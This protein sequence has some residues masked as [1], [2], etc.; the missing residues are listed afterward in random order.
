MRL[1]LLALVALVLP[2]AGCSARVQHGLDERQANEI[3]TVLMERGFRARKVVEEGRPPAWSVE[4]ESV[5]AADAVRVLAELGLPR[6]RPAGVRELLKPGLVPDPVE[7]HA[8]LLEAQSGELARTLEA[9]DG[10][11]SARVHLVRPQPTRT[12][13]PSSPTKAAV[14]LRAQPAASAHLQTVKDELRALVAG[15]V[16][17]LEPAAVTLVVSEVVSTVPPRAPAPERSAW[18]PALLGG[19]VLALG[20]A[21]GGGVLWA[22]RRARRRAA[23]ASLAL[24]PVVQSPLA[25]RETA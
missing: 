19:L 16:E 23:P 12:G 24:R 20:G 7:Q 2:G 3:Q 5:D 18:V 6:A 25:R 22:R 4:V 11:V 10:V 21:T 17:G 9:V 14:Y 1:P 15:S 8:L 13:V